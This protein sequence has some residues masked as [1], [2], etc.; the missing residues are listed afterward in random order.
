MWLG[1]D[2]VFDAFKFFIKETPDG[3]FQVHG[4]P[5]GD[6]MSTFIVETNEQ[7]WRRAGLDAGADRLAAARGQRRAE[8][9]VH[10]RAV[11]RRA[12]AAIS[13]SPTIRSG[14][15]S[16]RSATAAGARTMSCCSATPP[17][18][19]ISRSGRGP[20]SRWR[21][22]WRSRGPSGA[23]TM[24]AR[25]LAGYEDGAPP[26]RREHPARRAGVA[27]VV[28]GHLALRRPGSDAVRVQSADTQP[29]RHLRQPPAART[30]EF[31]D[32]VDADWPTGPRRRP[33]MFA[34]FTLRGLT[35][36]NRVVVS[37]MDMY[38]AVDGTPSETSTSCISVRARSAVRRSC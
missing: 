6:Q 13:C 5:Y 10:A 9:A 26:D 34:P 1:T 28:R 32:E 14:S 7:T 24:C 15:T 20:S 27:R 30:T 35:L 36:P 21:M 4:Y 11:R 25:R 29:P 2:L 3:V 18:R 16:S 12:R 8:R 38:S 17:T 31:V 23:P 19:P 37:P 22:R 33:P